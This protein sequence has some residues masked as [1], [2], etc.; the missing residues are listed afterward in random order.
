[1]SSAKE[2]SFFKSLRYTSLNMTKK[3]FSATIEST[4]VGPLW[5]RAKYSAIYPEILKDPL[6]E[7]IL[8]KLWQL[9]PEQQEGFDIMKEFI[10]EFAGL[11]FLFR[12]KKFDDELLKFK[13]IHPFATIIDL[14]CGLD[15]VNWRIGKN[16]FTWYYLD[17]PEAIA[18]REKLIPPQV[19]SKY[20]PKSIFN[21]TWFEDIEFIEEKG[22]M[23]LAAGLLNYFPEKRLR[24]LCDKMAEH[25]IGGV[26]LFDVP[27]AILKKIINKKF[28]KLGVEGVDNEFGLGTPKKIFNWSD[29]IKDVSCDIF[30]KG[31]EMNP[32]WKR[33]T[34][35][36]FKL[37]RVLKFYKFIRIEFKKE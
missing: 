7:M 10:D 15:T 31:L 23:F 30:F 18:L 14:G 32:K 11:N 34:R 17:L 13:A 5:A 29:R 33:K 27:S 19:N 6:A 4:M 1:M 37:S 20:I 22:I 16:D 36:L 8:Q 3:K 2:A 35:L 21:Y 24:E 9:Y 28:K 25:F 12:A 26:F